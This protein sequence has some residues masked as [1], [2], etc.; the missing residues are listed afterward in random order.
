[1]TFG[2]ETQPAVLVDAEKGIFKVARRNFV[3]PE[4]FEAEKERIFD[5]CWIYLGHGTEIPKPGDFLTRKVAGRSI[6]FSRDAKGV[7]HA[8]LNTCPHRGAQVCR[9]PKGNSK[10]F[11]CFYHGWVFGVDGQIRSVADEESYPADFKSRSCLDLPAPPHFDSYRDLYFVCFD[12]QAQSLSDY[13]GKAKE[14]LDLV[15]DQNEFGVEIVEGTHEYSMRANW[16]LLTEN[17]I[18]GYHVTMNHAS[19][20]DYLM[21]TSGGFNP[22]ESGGV[23]VDLGNGHAVLEYKAPWGRPVAQ[24]IPTWGEDGKAEIDRIYAGLVEK[25]GEERAHRIAKLNRNL[26]IFPNLVINDIMGTTIRTFYPEAENH[27]TITAWALAARGESDWARKYRLYNFLEFLGPGG[28]ATPDD[29][30]ALLHCQLGFQNW[31]E[32]PW[33]DISKGMHKKEARHNDE[34]QMRGFWSHWNKLMFPSS[35]PEVK[36]TAA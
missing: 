9:E 7:A 1:M 24:W 27:M 18:D 28:F 21:S 13:L 19:Y 2:T 14:Y 10:S 12:P 15:C 4:I 32:L 20:L 29:V 8:L 6:I 5:R 33:N 36:P 25:H 22:A 23:G 35:V 17:S 34:L 3:D 30:E 26:Y 11:Q 16:K 31:K